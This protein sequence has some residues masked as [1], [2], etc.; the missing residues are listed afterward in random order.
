MDQDAI[1]TAIDVVEE[2]AARVHE[3]V[4]AVADELIRAR[5]LRVAGEP[6]TVI[7]RHLLSAGGRELRLQPVEASDQFERAVT[8]YRVA[9]IRELIDVEG[10]SF[11][12]VAAMTGVSRQMVA[13]LYRAAPS[14]PDDR[15]A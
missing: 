2:A 4:D 8:S 5:E 7:V 12:Q 9:A 3:A 6:V 15:R 14:G 11:T 1:I 13:R 10:M